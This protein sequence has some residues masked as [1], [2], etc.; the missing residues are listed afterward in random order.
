MICVLED[1]GEVGWY[2]LVSSPAP[3][4]PQSRNSACV[5]LHGG[6]LLSLRAGCSSG[7]ARIGQRRVVG[8]T[9]CP[10]IFPHSERWDKR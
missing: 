3:A 5:H 9:V 7:T 4:T 10:D 2:M 6:V 1:M 8:D